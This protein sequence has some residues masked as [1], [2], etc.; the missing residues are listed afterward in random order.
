MTMPPDD[1]LAKA[2]EAWRHAYAP[3][4]GFHVGAAL[5]SSSG[6]V[7]SGA[8]IEN[9]SYGLTRC[10]EQSAVQ[11]MASTGERSFSEIVVYTEAD[12]P[13]PPCGACR[14]I[15]FEFNRDARVHLVNHA[16]VTRS[17]LVS[18]LLPHAFTLEP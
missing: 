2:R 10:A 9:T 14:Q 5:R 16:G 11:A 3:Y 7:F 4:S 6:T 15:L 18:D 17:F 13:A 12:Q 8:N 1:L